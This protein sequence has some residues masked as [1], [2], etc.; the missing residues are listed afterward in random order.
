MPGTAMERYE[1]SQ[2]YR[3][4]HSAA[5]VMAQAVM[6]LFPGEAKIAIGPPIEE[7]FY[8]DFDL[9]RSLT[10]EDLTRLEQRMRQILAG[11]HAFRREELSAADARRLFADQP[12]KIELIDGLERGGADEYG[13]PTDQT[14]VISTYT[15]D[16]FTDLCRGPHVA[17]LGQVNPDGVKL[18]SVAGA[19][20]RGDENSSDAS[21][22]LRH[23]LSDG[24]RTRA[25][26][27]DVGRGQAP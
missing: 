12:Y 1:D 8:Y 22:H 20:W 4:R 21:T 11:R 18:L 16:V 27:G 6:E 14:P 26:P 3:I 19:Y 7:G 10:P 24:R 17:D 25:A 5:H 15:H 9:P 13:N 23:G 2:L